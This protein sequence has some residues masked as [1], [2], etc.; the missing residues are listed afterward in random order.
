MRRSLRLRRWQKEALDR[1][2]T[3]ARRDFLAVATPGAGK[4]TFALTAA[5][6]DLGRHPHRRLVVVAPT[7]HLK[8]QWSNAAANFGLHLEPEWAS[9]EAFPHD[10]H[11]VVVTY[12]QVAAQ[13]RALRGPSDDAFVVLDEVHHAGTERAWGD[14]VFQAFELAAH[15]LSLSGTPFRSDQNP[16]PFVAY[17][18]EEAVADYVYGYGEA[19]KDGGVVR[20]VFFPRING[21]MEWSTPEG[22]IVSAT[23]DDHLDRTLSSQRLRTALSPDGE[24][25]P[26]VLEQAHTQLLRLR[27]S[28]PDAG[29]LVI[30]MDVEHARSIQKLLKAGHGVDAVV[31]TSDDPLASEK[32]ADFA[33][34]RDPWIVAVRMVSEGVDVPR[35][36]VGVY[37]TNTVTELFFRQAVGRLVRWSGSLRRQ[38][39]FM[40]IPD[41]FRL[42]TFATQIAEQ[43][44]HSLKRREEEGDQDPVDLLDQLPPEGEDQLSL[45]AAISAT[46]VVDHDP[47]SIFDDHHPEDLVHDPALEDFSL[48]IELAPPPPRAG[49]GA[50]GAPG[51]TL[52]V[53][54]T[55]RKR[56]LRQANTDRVRMLTHLTGLAPEVINGRLNR[57]SGVR[58]IT[59]ATVRDLERR[60]RAADTWIDRA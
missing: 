55:Q 27:E 22:A 5:V 3:T 33:A 57:E 39:A 25:L 38:K 35:L 43:R 20:P 8:H 41:D 19:L 13:P 17:D 51:T 24:W 15:R 28:Q 54:R 47:S 1:F 52:T 21:Q 50:E 46:A 36:R 4:T 56:E 26:T 12:Q 9:A 32:I 37:A 6:R 34:G 40:F 48:E 11:G 29:G 31:A 58:S 59:E 44:T 23:F 53:S 7:Q 10:M 49:G 42:R 16:I 18:F 2:E 14:G 30:A 60:L 45:F